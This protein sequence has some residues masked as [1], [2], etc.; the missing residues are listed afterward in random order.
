MIQNCAGDYA[1][2][3]TFQTT[4]ETRRKRTCVLCSNPSPGCERS[5]SQPHCSRRTNQAPRKSSIILEFSCQKEREKNDAFKWFIQLVCKSD[6]HAK[7]RRQEREKE[8]GPNL[9][10]VIS[11]QGDLFFGRTFL[12][13]EK[14]DAFCVPMQV[15]A[16]KAF[17]AL[18]IFY[19]KLQ[20][21][22][23]C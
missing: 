21:R 10:I 7:W 5:C 19:A 9:E 3:K 22:V 15:V 13:T 16:T 2:R 20:C 1:H 14:K 6:Y 11:R 18:R 17:R 23:S 8:R 12:E 4:N